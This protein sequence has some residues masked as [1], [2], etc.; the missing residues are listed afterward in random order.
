M[1]NKT[2][3]ILLLLA[4]CCAS[5]VS[6]DVMA[7]DYLEPDS[8]FISNDEGGGNLK[9]YYNALKQQLFPE[10]W[11][12]GY[13]SVPSFFSEYGIFLIWDSN[14]P[15]LVYNRFNGNYWYSLS[16]LDKKVV[17]ITIISDTIRITTEEADRLTGII[18][19]AIEQAVKPE[20]LGSL[21]CDGT[22]YYFMLP[23]KMA[24]IWSPRKDSECE[25][26]VK[27]FEDLRKQ[28]PSEQRRMHEILMY[29]RHNIGRLGLGYSTSLGNTPITSG[30]GPLSPKYLS[31]DLMIRRFYIGTEISFP[32]KSVLMTDDFYYDSKED[33]NWRNGE[34][35]ERF[36]LAIKAGFSF[37][38]RKAFRMTGF[39]GYNKSFIN[40]DTDKLDNKEKPITS[41][42]EIRRIEAGMFADFRLYSFYL[43]TINGIELSAGLYASRD[44][45]KSLEPSYSLNASIS[46]LLTFDP[47]F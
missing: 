4:F 9:E 6:F 40:Q 12:I 5:A 14:G 24:R 47:D 32:Y 33:Y 17:Q 27:V 45:M 23:D 16:E 30:I 19:D 35:I 43:G 31:L 42:I 25:K 22:N 20:G 8:I 21:G 29:I 11:S 28:F 2:H 1:K 39:I 13:L 26:L 15:M 46:L 37:I 18:T 41:E 7:Q 10:E 36:G 38:E 44:I 3:T 34:E